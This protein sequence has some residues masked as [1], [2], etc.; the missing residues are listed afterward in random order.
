MVKTVKKEKAL[1]LRLNGRS[2]NEI[3]KRLNVPKST[4]GVWCRNIRLG[5]TQIKR[6]SERIKSGSYKG[7]MKFLERIKR[8]RIREV[9]KLREEGIKEIGKLDKRDLS[10]A[11]I[12][13]YWS[14]GYTYT[15]GEQ[16][17]FT[18]SDPKMILFILKWFREICGVLN[19]NITL[20]VKINKI[21][22]NRIK[23]VENYWSKL[24]EIPLNQFNKTVLIKS[25]VKKVYPNHDNHY[26]T[27]RITVR[28]GTRLRRKIIGWIEGLTQKRDI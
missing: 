17:G 19:K 11:G 13:M 28:Q 12:A 5:P 9:N 1:K 10:I 24:T 20:Q 8:Q 2:L 15:G 3:S 27:L 4:V 14:E 6:L 23:K 18:N 26:G 16:V 25:K 22:K 7:R 21:H